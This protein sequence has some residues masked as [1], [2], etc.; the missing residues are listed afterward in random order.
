MIDFKKD[1]LQLTARGVFENPQ[2]DSGCSH[3][4]FYESNSS[5][6][7]LQILDFLNNLLIY[8]THHYQ[9][10]ALRTCYLDIDLGIP[11]EWSPI[12]DFLKE[13]FPILKSVGIISLGVGEVPGF[14]EDWS[15]PRKQFEKYRESNNPH[16]RSRDRN[17][18]S[19]THL[20]P[21]EQSI[22]VDYIKQYQNFSVMASPTPPIP[23]RV[24]FHDD[25]WK[26][27]TLAESESSEDFNLEAFLDEEVDV[28]TD[29]P[30]NFTLFP[31][32]CP[33]LRIKIWAYAERIF[34]RREH[35]ARAGVPAFI[36]FIN[37]EKDNI[38]LTACERYT[39]HND[40]VEGSRYRAA[41]Q[42]RVEK[43]RA[44]ETEMLP[45]EAVFNEYF[46]AIEEVGLVDEWVG[47]ASGY[48]G[49]QGSWRIPS[50]L[51]TYFALG[52]M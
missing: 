10:M 38:N 2:R 23:K 29:L 30:S 9:R 33:E 18:Y 7:P 21:D 19:F 8:A 25:F 27:D 39:P 35:K 28:V 45:I 17:P 48:G 12:A 20:N 32:L 36:S 43:V 4:Y 44:R 5:S 11:S 16:Q 24:P 52:D 50:H 6:P 22:T 42:P 47:E 31:K 41:P 37:F 49:P 3:L 13:T 34:D 40:S 15:Q 26:Y 1:T 51:W 14:D 46:P